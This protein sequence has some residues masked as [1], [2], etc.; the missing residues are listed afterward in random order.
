VKLLSIITWALII[1]VG[2]G[3]AE[4]SSGGG[5]FP[6]NEWVK[7]EQ[8]SLGSHWGMTLVY[9]PAIKR[10]L[11]AMGGQ[12]RYDRKPAPTY[13]EMSFNFQ[14]RRWE[15]ALP[16]GGE[17]WGGLTGSVDAPKF[18]KGPGSGL[19][20]DSSGVLRPKLRGGYGT[21]VYHL[22]TCDTDRKR[23]LYGVTMEYDPVARTWQKLRT[24]RHPGGADL[25]PFKLKTAMPAWSQSCYDPVKKEIL[26]FGG[27][28]VATETGAPGTWVFS[29]AKNEWKKLSFGG[30]E[31]N[32]LAGR[33][34]RLVREAHVVVTACRNRYYMTELPENA[35]QKLPERLRGILKTGDLEALLAGVKEA[36]P[37]AKGHLKQKL[38]WAS[39]ELKQALEGYRNLLAAVKSGC[40]AKTIAAASEVRR[41]LRRSETS[42][43]SEPPPRCYSPMVFDP[44]SKRIVLFGGSGLSHAKA[45]TWL[46]DP[47]TRTW[48]ERRPGLSPS[49][50]LGHGL[51]YLPKAKKVVLLGG[52]VGRPGVGC[53]V[54]I[55]NTLPPEAWTYDVESD[56]W[57]LVRRWA[58][59]GATTKSR[60]PAL[61]PPFLKPGNSPQFFAADEHDVVLTLGGKRATWA[62]RIDPSVTD[63]AGTAKHG[64]KPGV[65]HYP[66]GFCSPEWYDKSAPPPDAKKVEN[67]LKNL[68][69]NKWVRR[70][71]G[72]LKRP[73]NAYCSI[74]YDPDRDEIL[75]FVGGHGTWHGADVA[76]YSLAT[77]RWHTD[78]PAQI[79]L[80]FG[81]FATGGSYGYGFRPW[82]PV[83]TWNGYCYDTLTRKLVLVTGMP[84][85][86]F[87]YD[88]EAGDFERPW[89]K[90]FPGGDSW[91]CKTA[92]TPRGVCAWTGG[93]GHKAGLWRLDPQKK[94]WV[95]LP[96]KKGKVPAP[97]IDRATLTFDTK[98]DQLI[99]MN[100]VL[101]GD[102]LVYDFKTGVLERQSA[103][104]KEHAPGNFRD[105]RYVA[106]QD[107]IFEMMGSAYLMEKKEWVRLD[108]DTSALAKTRKGGRPKAASSRQGLIYDRRR[109][110]LWAV[111]GY[112]NKGVF[113]LKL[114][115]VKALK[116][117]RR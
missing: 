30:K 46:Y 66:G 60:K 107:L 59:S 8:G 1:T 99:A 96:V 51:V 10:F 34:R 5:G 61:P 20:P 67:E 11:V 21:K 102:I 75:T 6:A 49:P 85:L 74:A 64:V 83:H 105:C 27:T 36:T 104:G 16:R 117:R 45:D 106:S 79:P 56:K 18:K 54:F 58:V 93:R 3:A 7:L 97:D 43:S 29:S 87:T 114:D 55:G 68:P 113:V 63:S 19:R 100:R 86:T 9:C 88:L 101:K 72:G 40:D 37:P 76:R 44:V 57:T 35:K 71:E 108:I 23:V 70:S 12:T 52:W 81:Y 26:L 33:S 28:K 90:L 69:V 48:E 24:G 17:K 94:T 47:E 89:S 2:A 82:M 41:L 32:R 15:N 116:Q 103:K 84:K 111:N 92:R 50:R 95:S 78:F 14:K 31:L 39:D 112:S 73:T 42:L 13:S 4:K 115:A 53:N 62:C 80:S 91:T 25:S 109:D 98:R 22:V 65:E 110:L 77:D 38:I